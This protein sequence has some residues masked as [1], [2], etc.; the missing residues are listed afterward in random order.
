MGYDRTEPKR[1][2]NMTLN[3][4]LV[5][6]ALGLSTNLSYKPPEAL[7][8]AMRGGRL[9]SSWFCTRPPHQ[10]RAHT[11]RPFGR[12]VSAT[13]E[14]LLAAFVEAAKAMERER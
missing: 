8:D 1:P 2:V 5:R 14:I 6:R 11:G 3:E 13:V 9:V 4:D 10:P 7:T 12:P